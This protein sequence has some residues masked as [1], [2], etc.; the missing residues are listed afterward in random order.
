[1]GF[2]ST[3]MHSSTTE[4]ISFLFPYMGLISIGYN[5]ESDTITILSIPLYGI[6]E[7]DC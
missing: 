2:V 4:A 6:V 3:E 1:M 7:N 5:W